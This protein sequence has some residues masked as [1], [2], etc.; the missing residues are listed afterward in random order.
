M[1]KIVFMVTALMMAA[2]SGSDRENVETET[3]FETYSGFPYSSLAPE[4]QKV[5]LAAEAE[6]VMDGAASVKDCGVFGIIRAF[7][8]MIEKSNMFPKFRDEESA[9]FGIAT[10]NGVYTWDDAREGFTAATATDRLEFAF[11]VLG[12]SIKVAVKSVPSGNTYTDQNGVKVSIPKEVSVFIHA[13]DVEIGRAIV[14]AGV[15]GN[16]KFPLI[17]GMEYKLCDHSLTAGVDKGSPNMVHATLKAG[18]KIIIDA[19]GSMT[20]S[21]DDYFEFVNRDQ[22]AGSM[23]VPESFV[24]AVRIGSSLAVAGSVRVRDLGAEEFRA[25]DIYLKAEKE[26]YKIYEKEHFSEPALR[27]YIETVRK[28]KEVRAMAEAA[29]FER[30]ADVFLVS[31]EDRTRIAKLNKRAKS[32]YLSSEWGTALVLAFGDKTEQEAAVYFSAGFDSLVEKFLKY[33]KQAEELF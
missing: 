9:L 18:E 32:D 11:T 8:E 13:D 29:A 22:P 7:V 17:T 3:V 4:K 33:A 12:K 27:V 16:N 15:T 23:P 10:F 2:C 6:T 24:S 30:Y 26:A 28:A 1:K 5:K 25:K 20:G 21:L 31:T 14:R 19:E